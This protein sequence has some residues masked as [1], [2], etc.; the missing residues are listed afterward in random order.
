MGNLKQEDIVSWQDKNGNI[1]CAACGDPDDC[2]PLTK[3]DFEYD[4]VVHCDGCGERIQ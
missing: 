3:D 2:E 4:D 1:Y